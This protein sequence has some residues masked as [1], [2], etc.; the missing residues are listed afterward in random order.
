ML[1]SQARETLQGVEAVIV[2]EIHAVAKTKRGS[3][4]SV[5]MERLVEVTDRPGGPQRIGLSATQRPLEEIAE[6]LGGRDDAGSWRTGDLV[7]A[8]VRKAL[9][10]DVIVPVEYIGDPCTATAEPIIRQ[11]SPDPSPRR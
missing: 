5:T 9:D 7:D 10:I 4:L 11:T 3:H 2:D 6:F 8:G 1:T